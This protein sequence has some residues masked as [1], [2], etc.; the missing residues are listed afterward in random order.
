MA[1]RVLRGE[2][3]PAPYFLPTIEIP[4]SGCAI[5]TRQLGWVNIKVR[6]E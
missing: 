3:C 1:W 2:V 4:A 6:A 5:E